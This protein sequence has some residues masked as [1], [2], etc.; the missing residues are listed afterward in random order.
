MVICSM[1]AMS[2]QQKANEPKYSGMTNTS[3][4]YLTSGKNSHHSTFTQAVN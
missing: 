3:N 1:M 2:L 4:G